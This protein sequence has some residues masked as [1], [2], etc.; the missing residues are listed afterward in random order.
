MI[1]GIIFGR[2]NPLIPIDLV[3]ERWRRLRFK[4]HLFHLLVIYWKTIILKCMHLPSPHL[5]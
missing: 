5:I 1:W 4:C 3:L 2:T